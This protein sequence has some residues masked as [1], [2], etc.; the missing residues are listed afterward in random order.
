MWPSIHLISFSLVSFLIFCLMTK[1]LPGFN[2]FVGLFTLVKIDLLEPW[3]L[4]TAWVLVLVV[5]A[6]FRIYCYAFRLNSAFSL[7]PVFFDIFLRFSIRLL[8]VA[9]KLIFCIWVS[10]ILLSFPLQIKSNPP[11]WSSDPVKLNKTLITI[12]PCRWLEG[13]LQGA[14]FWDRSRR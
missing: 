1:S 14:P 5:V 12:Y 4:P 6:S 3:A 13:C 2:C 11:I 10:L 8:S 7:L 9:R